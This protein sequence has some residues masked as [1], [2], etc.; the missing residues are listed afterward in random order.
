MKSDDSWPNHL[1]KGLVFNRE[2]TAI[3]LKP[4]GRIP[5][6]R[7]GLKWFHKVRKKSRRGDVTNIE[8][9]EW[10]FQKDHN[11][12]QT[13]T[14]FSFRLPVMCCATPRSASNTTSGGRVASPSRS[15]N[16]T[17]SLAPW[18]RWGCSFAT[19]DSRA[20]SSKAECFIPLFRYI[21]LGLN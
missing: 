14:S 5:K 7:D 8:C 1:N 6:E 21:D 19:C 15:S 18:R 9:S 11:D 13:K 16:G 2:Q 3:K 4:T 17:T 10:V 12:K 20:A